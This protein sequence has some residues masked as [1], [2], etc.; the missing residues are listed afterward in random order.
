MRDLVVIGGGPAGTSGAFAAAVFGQKVTLVEAC[1]D[2]GGAGINTGTIPSKTLRESAL[3]LSGAKS[4]KLLGIEVQRREQASLRDFTYHERHVVETGRALVTKRASMLGVEVIH[5][6][7]RFISPEEV[8]VARPDGS[9]LRIRARKF[10]IATGSKPTRPAEYD[11][12]H[13]LIHDSDEIL[14]IHHVPSSITIVGAGVIGTEYAS[15]FAA[16][17]VPVHIVDGRDVLLPFLD[18]E[19]GDALC[20]AMQTN[21][22]TFHFGEKVVSCEPRGDRV[23]IHLSSGRELVTSDVLVAAGR[24]CSTGSLGLEAAGVTVGNR[25]LIPVNEHFQTSAPHIYAAGD[26][27]GPPA[28]AATAMEYARIAMLHA[29]RSID[30]LA[31]PIQPIG[32]YSIPESASVGA[33][34]EELKARN[35][36]YVVGRSLYRDN[37]RGAIIGEESGFLKLLFDARDMRLLG[38][39]ILGESAI[40]LIHIGMIAIQCEKT[41][42]TF[43]RACFNYPTLTNLYKAATYDAMLQSM[44]LDARNLF[45]GT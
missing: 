11:F 23:H 45:S 12:H 41:A 17:G 26:V 21:G 10:L 5:G 28:V 6:L 16:L 36:P 30:K 9:E 27:I 3:L 31:N 40:E 33:T 35:I 19:L 13:S 38:A 22:I 39:H 15:T 32:I 20:Q 44:N 25:G 42:D 43:D 29:F 14:N 7:A 34:E 2:L 18:R 4:R 1:P 37:H 24:Q 8:A